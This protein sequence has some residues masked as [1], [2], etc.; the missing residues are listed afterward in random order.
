MSIFMPQLTTFMSGCDIYISQEQNTLALSYDYYY[1][2]WTVVDKTY[3]MVHL[4]SV[5]LSI[6]NLVSMQ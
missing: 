6:T 3:V 2:Y 5:Y 4:L 1:Y